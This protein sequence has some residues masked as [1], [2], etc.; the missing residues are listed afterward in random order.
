MV[1]K[2]RY[3]AKI[4]AKG[5]EKVLTEEQAGQFCRNQGTGGLFI[6]RAHAGPKVVDED[7]SETVN[8]I[9]D[10]VEFVPATHE[11]LVARFQRALYLARPDQFGQE[12]FEGAT[13][14]EPKV[15]DT[16]RE[17][18]AAVETDAEGEPTGVWTGDPEAPLPGDAA[19][20]A[21][22]PEGKGDDGLGDDGKPWPGDEPPVAPATD[23]VSKARS[24]RG[25]KAKD[26]AAEG[27]G[28][29]AADRLAKA[30]EALGDDEDPPA[31]D[32]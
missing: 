24:K 5:L 18:D 13:S 3:N 31:S 4:N 32:G 26:A 29:E 20:A 19:D 25:A 9:P 28:D 11:D 10:E 27:T 23:E 1:D 22:D 8:L 12:A 30:R 2:R 21:A 7:G 15:A 17:L 14:G 16:A 6:V